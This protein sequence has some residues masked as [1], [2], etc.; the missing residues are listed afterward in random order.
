[1]D[2]LKNGST[3]AYCINVNEENNDLGNRCYIVWLNKFETACLIHELAH[4]VMYIFDDHGIPICIE[5]TETFSY[6]QEFWFNEMS[7]LRRRLL[8]GNRPE[9][10]K[11]NGS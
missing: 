1:M 5:N 2:G 6:Y 11:K 3:T 7:R 4:L 10:V 9:Q 8:N